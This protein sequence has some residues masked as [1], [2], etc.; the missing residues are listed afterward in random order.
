M[1]CA[2]CV[3]IFDQDLGS[4]V[5]SPING[6][7]HAS[8]A[9]V[10]AAA[11]QGCYLCS[12][13]TLD[14]DHTDSA[15]ETESSFS[16]SSL[17]FEVTT[18]SINSPSG[19]LAVLTFESADGVLASS[20]YEIVYTGDILKPPEYDAY[21]QQTR[22]DLAK[23]PWRVRDD[24]F[25][26]SN[27]PVP[28]STGDAEVLQIAARWLKKCLDMHPR[29]NNSSDE[30]WYPK[31]LLDLSAANGQRVIV[32]DEVKP[33]GRYATLSH[34]WGSNVSIRCLT[35]DNLEEWKIG[36]PDQLLTRTFHDAISAAR[37]LNI[38]YLWIDSLCIM[39]AGEGSDEDWQE[40][41]V[42][43]R[44][45]YSHSLVNIAAARAES[46]ADG[47]FTTRADTYLRPC[48]VR[49]KRP[50][51]VS[52]TAADSFWTIRRPERHQAQSLR[53]S[54]LYTRGWVVQERFLAPRVLHF[55]KD[56]I[57]WEC[58]ELGLVEES[59]PVG[60]KDSCPEYDTSVSWAFDLTDES[61]QKG[62]CKESEGYK[63]PQWVWSRWQEVINGYTGCELSFP[64]KDILYA[65]AGIAEKFGQ[66]FNHQYVAGLF[67][68]HL[69]FDLLWQNK[70]ERSE[71]Y[72]APSWSWASIDGQV[73][74]TVEECPY[75]DTC[76]NRFATVKNVHVD[77]VHEKMVYG[78]VSQ[79]TLTL[80]GYLWPCR[81][82]PA[83]QA[84]TGLRQRIDIHWQAS[85]NDKPPEGPL[86]HQN[87]I[88]WQ[89][90]RGK[91]YPGWSPAPIDASIIWGEAD[92]DDEDDSI[93]G[94]SNTGHF[95]AWA[96]PIMEFKVPSDNRY[97]NH[98][99]LLVKKIGNDQYER[100]GIYRVEKHIMHRISADESC[101]Q[102]DICL[103]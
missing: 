12:E 51:R 96:V 65:V 83:Q 52:N 13:L 1:L 38:R 69:P 94:F 15:T 68:Q 17:S 35:S 100:L 50:L 103:V 59:F 22:A 47:A 90:A 33:E 64:D 23:E 6:Q 99:G 76:C 82:E 88:Y 25:P 7:H 4:S 53:T 28:G 97:A 79:A 32:T 55:G 40:H 9:N 95:H 37:M 63:S 8:I 77:L 26:T 102:Q 42:A 16:K 89:V 58:T 3:S 24:G 2:T 71:D 60:F 70:G 93:A 27:A 87:P 10:E 30:S 86:S 48:H 98:W 75:C 5:F 14:Y 45:V 80:T 66:H 29:C 101:T 34:C 78:P 44:W 20:G 56:R 67:R 19:R 92:I 81:I 62:D 18:H 74:F 73:H 39:Q 54:P 49:W 72:R 43:M 61:L 85:G 31:R 36:I 57:Y 11:A 91:Q 84:G 21:L 46:G 41:A